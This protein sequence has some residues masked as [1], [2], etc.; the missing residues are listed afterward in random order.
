MSLLV[1]AFD[2]R[3]PVELDEGLPGVFRAGVADPVD[4]E[5]PG[6]GGVASAVE[7]L[8]RLVLALAVNDDLGSAVLRL[9]GVSVLVR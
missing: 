1:G 6:T 8:L 7:D 2:I 5:L 9:F 4:E 3:A